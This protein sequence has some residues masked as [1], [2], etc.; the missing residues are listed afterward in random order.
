MNKELTVVSKS[1]SL[2]ELKVQLEICKDQYDKIN[3]ETAFQYIDEI[4]KMTYGLM[5]KLRADN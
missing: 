1:K 5:L 2:V 4:G 3:Y